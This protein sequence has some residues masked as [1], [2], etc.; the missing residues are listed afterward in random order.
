M[1][2]EPAVVVGGAAAVE[3][4]AVGADA[5]RGGR[6]VVSRRDGLVLG[7]GALLAV[8]SD[9]A[10]G[11]GV[12]GGD[13]VVGE[14]DGSRGVLDGSEGTAL[15]DS[16][17]VVAAV[18]AGLVDAIGDLP[19]L[20][21]GVGAA[22]ADLGVVVGS[23][24]AGPGLLV[25]DVLVDEAEE[26]DIGVLDAVEGAGLGLVRRQ[27]A[28]AAVRI[29]DGAQHDLLEV[30]RAGNLTGL[31]ARLR[32]RRQQHRRQD[33]DNRND[34]EQLNQRESSHLHESLLY[35]CIFPQLCSSS[36]STCYVIPIFAT[37]NKTYTPKFQKKLFFL[38]EP[39]APHPDPP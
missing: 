23:G 33:G 39:P 8:E 3:A 1:S 28:V 37:E 6:G 4:G 14:E 26:V 34:H 30:A 9:P 19:V 10:V 38:H 17:G 21:E 2:V 27:H 32:Q 16:G 13:D 7:E 29:L 22:V 35:V 12:G 36:P 15:V 5:V 31:L 11:G 25:P 18:G 24:G 20:G